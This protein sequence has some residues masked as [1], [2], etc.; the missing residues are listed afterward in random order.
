MSTPSREQPGMSLVT[1]FASGVLFAIGLIVA[2]MTDPSKVVAFLDIT[3]AWD[4]SLAFVMVGAI[5]VHFLLLTRILGRPR[6]VFDR[7]FFIPGTRTIDAPLVVGAVLFGVGWGLGGY[8]PGPAIVALP[9]MTAEA[10]LFGGAMLVG[11]W[12]HR[13]VPT[14][15]GSAA[16]RFQRAAS[17][18]PDVDDA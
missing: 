6:P 15:W 13:H 12:A 10:L 18:A 14:W 7:E 4:P 8:C 2:G 17:S 9:S 16:R 5:A 11:M 3:G 1:S